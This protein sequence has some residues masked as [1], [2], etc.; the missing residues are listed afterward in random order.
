MDGKQRQDI[1]QQLRTRINHFVDEA[2]AE[3]RK[4]KTLSLGDIEDI[5]LAVRAKVGQE[6]AQTL[7]Q[8]QATV[9]VPGPRCTT[10]GREM[11]YKGLKKRRIVSRSGEVDWERPYYYCEACRR[12]FFPPG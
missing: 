12:G 7:V 9:S 3:A 11:H 8:E 10:C 2:L 5:A 6:V 4:D 1:E